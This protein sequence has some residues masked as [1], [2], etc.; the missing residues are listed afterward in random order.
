MILKI[1]LWGGAIT[2][3]VFFIQISLYK[4]L[5]PLQQVAFFG[6]HPM[7]IEIVKWFV[8]IAFTEELLK[9]AV[10]KINVF[11]SYAMDE[12]MDIML[13]MVVVALGFAAVE[14]ILYL[15]T[16]IPGMSF[17]AIVQ[18]TIMISFI[19]FIGATFLHTLCSGLVGYFWALSSLRNKK[20]LQLTLVGI[21]LAAL[22]HGLYDFSIITLESTFNVI[23]PIV[24]IIALVIFMMYD[25]NEIKKIKSICKL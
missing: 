19:R 20:G 14:N 6:A 5:V 23:L 9:Y 13:Y 7:A 15:F 12:P 10:V 17:N 8:I 22:L 4:L 1:F 16:P 11:G 2:V 18:T 25:F 3:P 21:L 24:I